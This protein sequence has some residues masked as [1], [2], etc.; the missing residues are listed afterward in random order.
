MI[1][2]GLE[3]QEDAPGHPCSCGT[4]VSTCCAVVR[5]TREPGGYDDVRPVAWP[6]F[7]VQPPVGIQLS[8][9]AVTMHAKPGTKDD[10]GD[11]GS[12]FHLHGRLRVATSWPCAVTVVSLAE[13]RL[14]VIV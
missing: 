7:A 3:F 4:T 1:R 13:S 6:D 12:W 11:G 10:D 5:L 9:S 8:R 14:K 2:S